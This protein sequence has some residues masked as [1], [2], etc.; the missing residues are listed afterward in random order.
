MTSLQQYSMEEILDL[1]HHVMLH[2]KGSEREALATIQKESN[3]RYDT[4]VQVDFREP[5][6]SFV[7]LGQFLTKD[8]AKNLSAKEIAEVMVAEEIAS[9][10]ELKR[11]R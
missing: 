7:K 3:N 1:D 4:T 11:R 5:K 2:I 6:G 10:S 8:D 9:T